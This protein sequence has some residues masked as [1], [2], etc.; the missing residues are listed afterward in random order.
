MNSGDL[1]QR[2]VILDDACEFRLIVTVPQSLY[3]YDAGF[4]PLKFV[5]RGP[6]PPRKNG[7][8]M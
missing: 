1:S 5:L 3:A 6:I 8:A 2:T 4:E 7:T